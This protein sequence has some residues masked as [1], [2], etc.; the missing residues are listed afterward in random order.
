M[1]EHIFKSN[2]L[3]WVILQLIYKWDPQ[4]TS[5]DRCSYPQKEFRVKNSEKHADKML[6]F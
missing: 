1:A 2:I 6:P 5:S 3:W 4:N